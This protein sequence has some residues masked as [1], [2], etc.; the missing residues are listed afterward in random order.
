MTA[1]ADLSA[2]RSR[3]QALEIELARV[4]SQRNKAWRDRA[5]IHAS[6]RRI[7]SPFPQNTSSPRPR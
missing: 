3:I 4:K 7:T 2:L 6:L 5:E 1:D